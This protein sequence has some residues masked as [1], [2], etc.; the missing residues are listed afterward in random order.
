MRQTQRKTAH[1]E[2]VNELLSG[3]KER[4]KAKVVPDVG[5]RPGRVARAFWRREET[6]RGGG[7]VWKGK[8][9]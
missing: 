1:K 6:E 9:W 3:E 4:E 8:G 5:L 2:V 7:Q